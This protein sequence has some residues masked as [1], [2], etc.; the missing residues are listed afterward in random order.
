[1]DRDQIIASYEQQLTRIEASRAYSDQAK[2]IMAA[3]AYTAAQSAM[4]QLR[5]STLQQL[6]SRRQDVRRRM[7]G[8]TDTSDAQTLMARRDAAQKAAELD[9]PRIAREELQEALAQG[10]SIMARAIAARADEWGWN[11]VLDTYAETRPDFRRLAEEFNTTPNP[12]DAD[13]RFRHNFAHVVA[14]PN[15]LGQMQEHQIA[16]L[17]G[18]DIEDAA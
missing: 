6:R 8:H 13:W 17:A 11:D 12:D 2:R 16:A 15:L 14:P 1:M 4:N 3:K 5:D 10:D 7:Y 9:N 18:Q